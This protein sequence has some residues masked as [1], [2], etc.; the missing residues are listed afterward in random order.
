M[1]YA[2]M[3]FLKPGAVRVPLSVEEQT[4]EFLGQPLLKIHFAGPLRNRAGEREAMLLIFE[5]STREGAESY[6][7]DSPYLRAGLYE[8]HRL[9]EFDNEV[10]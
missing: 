2:W 8:N 9:Y 5:H 10:G 3:G 6:V 7:A 4:N 1:L